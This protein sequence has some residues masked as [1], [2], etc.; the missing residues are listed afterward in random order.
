MEEVVTVSCFGS[1]TILKQFFDDCWD[2]YLK[3]TKN[4]ITIFEHSDITWKRT[5][6]KSIRPISI[7]IMN[8]EVKVELIRDIEGFLHQG[9][10]A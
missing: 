8:E 4:K 2:A 3:L 10:P 7:I 6:V 1:P 9:A 5:R